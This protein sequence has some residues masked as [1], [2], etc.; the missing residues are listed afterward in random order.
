[1]A[2]S[3][4]LLPVRGFSST[5][6][7]GSDESCGFLSLACVRVFV[8]AWPAVLVVSARHQILSFH[9]KDNIQLTRLP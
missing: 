2:V 4:E 6:I 8:S 1:M 9:E 3:V 5:S 7:V